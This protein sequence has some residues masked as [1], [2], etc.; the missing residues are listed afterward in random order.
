M[1]SSNRNN[2]IIEL[3]WGYEEMK[4]YESSKNEMHYKNI[5]CEK[6]EKIFR[7]KMRNRKTVNERAI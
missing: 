5:V 3:L 7:V 1:R 4:K 6:C 2:Y